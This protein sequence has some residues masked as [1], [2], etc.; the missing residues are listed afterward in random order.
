MPRRAS[1]ADL[2]RPP[3]LLRAGAS[4]MPP[5]AGRVSPASWAR[6]IGFGPGDGVGPDGTGAAPV[7]ALLARQWPGGA[8]QPPAPLLKHAAELPSSSKLLSNYRTA[9]NRAVV[10]AAA[11]DDRTVQW[12]KLCTQGAMASARHA[13]EHLLTAGVLKAV[14]RAGPQRLRAV[15]AAVLAA[16]LGGPEHGQLGGGRAL[17][18]RTRIRTITLGCVCG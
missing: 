14:P 3:A 11:G 12:G 8:R 10:T 13:V 5:L 1:L 16:E 18:A 9:L 4:S 17:E 15:A 2:L 6:A 7:S